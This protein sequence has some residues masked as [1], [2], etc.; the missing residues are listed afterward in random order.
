LRWNREGSGFYFNRGRSSKVFEYDLVTERIRPLPHQWPER[1]LSVVG[2]AAITPDG[3][4]YAVN[5]GTVIGDVYVL[6]GLESS[7]QGR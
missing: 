1:Q 2:A 3:R 4:A 7:G 6:T 5:Y